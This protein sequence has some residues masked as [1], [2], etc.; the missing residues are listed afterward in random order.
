MPEDGHD[1]IIKFIPPKRD[2]RFSNNFG[3]GEGIIIDF[4][5]GKRRI[6]T[7]KEIEQMYMAEKGKTA[8]EVAAEYDKN[9]LDL[10]KV[11][12]KMTDFVLNEFETEDQKNLELYQFIVSLSRDEFL[13]KGVLAMDV[14]LFTG[15]IVETLK[16]FL[17]VKKNK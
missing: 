15:T 1:N 4:V 6:E 12:N 13:N 7:Y 16:K 9:G 17:E 5:E 3:E 8:E 10:K 14:S 2:G 11:L